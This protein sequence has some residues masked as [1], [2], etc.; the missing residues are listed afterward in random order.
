MRSQTEVWEPDLKIGSEA[1]EGMSQLLRWIGVWFL[2]NR[3]GV[4]SQLRSQ[5]GVWER[6]VKAV[7][8]REYY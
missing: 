8:E 1:S 4:S 7:W 5:T 2:I 3:N 6:E